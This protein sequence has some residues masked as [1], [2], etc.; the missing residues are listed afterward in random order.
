M[1]TVNQLVVSRSTC[2]HIAPLAAVCLLR[3]DDVTKCVIGVWLM[4]SLHCLCARCVLSATSQL[5]F[6][7][8]YIVS[9]SSLSRTHYPCPERSSMRARL[10]W[11]HNTRRVSVL[12]EFKT[13]NWD[14]RS[15][16]NRVSLAANW[17]L[18]TAVETIVFIWS[19]SELCCCFERIFLF[20]F[21]LLIFLIAEQ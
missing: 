6:H 16:V 7:F 5:K 14:A 3:R 2:T 12:I 11:G 4:Q 8:Y 15:W 1:L 17:W 19:K 9:S 21:V 13:T 20:V 18:M 10:C